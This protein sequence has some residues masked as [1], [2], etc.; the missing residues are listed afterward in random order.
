MRPL[1]LVM[2]AFGPYAGRTELELDKLGKGGIYL[3]TGDTGAGKTIIFDAIT[4]AL[5][6]E[7]SGNNRSRDSLRSKYAEASTPTL[8]ELN[9]EYAGKEYY[10][11]RNPQYERPKKSGQ[12][13]TN[14]IAG[15]ELHYPDGRVISKLKDVDSAVTEIMGIDRSQFSQIAM[16]AQ[17]DFLKLLLASTDERKK[18]FQKIF[19]TQNYSALQDAIKRDTLDLTRERDKLRDSLR[20]YFGE[21]L[22]NEEDPLFFMVEKARSGEMQTDEILSLL[23]D[24]IEKDSF[25][26]E[27]L[28][29]EEKNLSRQLEGIAAQLAKAEEQ[30]KAE[31]SL[32][33][34]QREYEAESRRSEQ[35]DNDLEEQEKK[36]PEID[37][38]VRSIAALRAELP[39]YAELDKLAGT[40]QQIEKK[41][42]SAEHQIKEKTHSLKEKGEEL[43]QRKAEL[44]SLEK[45]GEEKLK[46]ESEKAAASSLLDSIANIDDEISQRDARK[47]ELAKAQER[48]KKAAAEAERK[49]R[50]HDIKHK[51]YL[52]EQ[53]GI[54]AETLEDG[55]PCP[56]CGSLEH[57]EPASKS[58]D[59]PG[60]EELE[61]L[62]KDA[63]KADQLAAAASEKAGSI[64]TAVE[65]RT[66][67]IIEHITRLLQS[68]TRSDAADGN[69]RTGPGGSTGDAQ[70]MRL[71]PGSEAAQKTDEDS[72]TGMLPKDEG[73]LAGDLSKDEESLIVLLRRLEVDAA[74]RVTALDAQLS[75]VNRLVKRKGQL[76]K[77]V[78]RLTE[79]QEQLRQSVSAL[80]KDLAAM[81]ASAASN[82]EQ[83]EKL[84]DKLNYS[85]EAEAEKA[86]ES[87]E[88]KKRSLENAL[89]HASEASQ[90]ARTKV[91][92]LK[93]SIEKAEKELTEREDIDTEALNLK[94]QELSEKRNIGAAARMETHT[95]S[96]TNSSIL[97]KIETRSEEASRLEKKE[98]W[99]KSLSDTA[100]GTISGKEKIML[101]IF[102]QMTY[103]DRIISRANT[104]LMVMSGG[105]YELKRRVESANLRSQSGLDLDVIDHYNG[106]IRPVSSLSGGEQFKA[107]LSLALG[108]SEEIQSS[109]GGIR[110]DTMFVDEGFGTL[111]EES[112]RQAMNALAGL[113]EGNRLVGIISHVAE[114][115]EK[116]DKQIIVT[117]DRTGGS[118]AE[119]VV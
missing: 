15:A 12:G 87:I 59:A 42:R 9:F 4:F 36:R 21:I 70:G 3:I 31:E 65:E 13:T 16:I 30:Q 63:E 8:V 106:S 5:Y 102:I 18:I 54:L 64:N 111:D 62:K 115:K 27:K 51:A 68:E 56:V 1:K 74:E 7:P 83:L 104:R 55:Q 109:A 61:L 35:L 77:L 26:E 82:Q 60:R 28:S 96:E 33:R 89:K 76:E 19:Q 37:Q 110:L 75:Q 103:F 58:A 46:L 69:K 17:G 112:L 118:R 117:K 20:Q 90:N 11:K 40:L 85:S 107:S 32:L 99:M 88:A 84:S 66:A 108:L 91:D 101:E 79:E 34:L 23:K 93:L 95:R 22:C 49:K 48:Y 92:S 10:I 113:A 80:E 39:E 52:D 57:P 94:K 105:Q 53:A 41:T 45:A 119:I 97:K 81:A 25:A 71:D 43:Q 50:E 44:A 6:G 78:P 14:E 86:V 38:L 72:M 114:L 116:I 98:A 67:A 47:R 100:N 24:L 73:S 29:E 2:S